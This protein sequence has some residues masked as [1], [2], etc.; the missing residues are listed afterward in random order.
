MINKEINQ[1][2]QKGHLNHYLVQPIEPK[3]LPQKP[4]DTPT[5]TP[6]KISTDTPVPRINIFSPTKNITNLK[7]QDIFSP[8]ATPSLN[9]PPNYANSMI[10]DVKDWNEVN[11]EAKNYKKHLETLR[12]KD[13]KN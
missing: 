2:Q 1:A 8:E 4:A 9:I 7:L 6:S 12:Q 13:S 5:P 10:E 3:T 11:K